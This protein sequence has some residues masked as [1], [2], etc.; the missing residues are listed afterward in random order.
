M[1]TTDFRMRLKALLHNRRVERELLEELDFH[2]EMQTR[3]NLA[4]GMSPAEARVRA[5]AQFGST[6]LIGD[7]VRDARGITLL[8]TIWQ[9]VRYSLRSFRRAPTFALTVIGTIALAM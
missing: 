2:V 8:E 9:D 4:A 5:C 6:A 7:Q 1:T 3:K